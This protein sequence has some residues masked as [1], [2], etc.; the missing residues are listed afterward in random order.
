M[1]LAATGEPQVDGVTQAV[2]VDA[3]PAIDRAQQ[4]HRPVGRRPPVTLGDAVEA[5]F[6][7]ATGNRV[8][9][10]GE[11]VAEIALSLVAVELVGA[12]GTVGIGRHVVLE[13][14]PSVGM[15]RASARSPAG[16]SPSATLP[17]C[18][19]ASRILVQLGGR[20]ASTRVS[21]PKKD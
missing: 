15:A 13:S 8:E 16:S 14:V 20:A 3:G 9:G 18:L 19:C 11:P 2:E 17:S 10:A 4:G 7:V 1:E 5:R 12:L 21:A 6:H